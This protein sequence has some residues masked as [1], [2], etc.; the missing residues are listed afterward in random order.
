VRVWLEGVDGLK[1]TGRF[2]AFR[3]TGVHESILLGMDAA[4]SLIEAT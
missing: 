2:G 3:G 4:S 1:S